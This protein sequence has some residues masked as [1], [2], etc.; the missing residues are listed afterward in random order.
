MKILS[1]KKQNNLV[2]VIFFMQNYINRNLDDYDRI[3]LS[4][5]L[6]EITSCVLDEKHLIMLAKLFKAQELKTDE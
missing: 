1:N 6:F 5:K 2:D 3:K 4:D